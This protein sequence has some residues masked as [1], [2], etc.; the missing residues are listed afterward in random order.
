MVSKSGVANFCHVFPDEEIV[1]NGDSDEGIAFRTSYGRSEHNV[2][3]T[4]GD[5]DRLGLGA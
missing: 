1:W 3:R 5:F 4:L 2:S